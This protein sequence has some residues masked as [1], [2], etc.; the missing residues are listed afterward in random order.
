MK[1]LVQNYKSGELTVREIPAPQL[2]AG[3]VLVRTAYSLISAGTERGMVEMA[4]KSLVEK[5]WSRPDLVRKVLDKARTEGVLTAYKK[6]MLRLST[7]IPLG[8]SS[9][10]TVV[11]VGTGVPEFKSGIQV[12]C[13]GIGYASHSEIVFVPKNLCV[14]VPESVELREAAFT[15]VGTI[16]LQ[17]VR[18]AEVGLGDVVAVIGLGLVGLL[19]VQILKSCGCHVVGMDPDS[20]RC[21]L[22]TELGADATA[23]DGHEHTDA[24]LRLSG[25]LGA[26][27]ALITAATADSGPLELAGES[28]RDRARVVVVGQV[29][30]SVPRKLYYEKELSLLMS[31]SYGPGRYDRS[32]EEKG[33]D[34]PAGYVR[35]TENRNMGA[36][37]KLIAERKLDV[38][39]L[40]THEFPLRRALDAYN[41]IL[42]SRERYL[43]VMLT[44]EASTSAQIS[45]VEIGEKSDRPGSARGTA[46]SSIG[47]GVI[48]SG[49][50]C[51]GVILPALS[52]QAGVSLRG[53]C[54]Q[55]GLTARSVGDRWKFSYCTSDTDAIVNDESTECVIIATRPDSHARLVCAALEAGKHVFVEKPLAVNI[56]QLRQIRNV[57][58]VHPSQVLM[59]GFNRRFSPYVREVKKFVERRTGP[60]MA[61]YRVNAGYLPPTDWQHD[62]E[63]GAGRI[64][65]ESGHFVDTLCYLTGAIPVEVFASSV[66]GSDKDSSAPENAALT[67]RFKDG[68]VGVVFYTTQ[69]SPAFSKERLELFVDG[70]VA[71]IDDFRHIE[72]IRNGSRKKRKD[73]LKQ[74]KGHAAEIEAFLEAVRSGSCPVNRED[75][76]HTTL[77]TLL[78]VESLTSGRRQE[79]SANSLEEPVLEPTECC[80]E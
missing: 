26:D 1:Q 69:G 65:G 23:S 58:A 14:A 34:Y 11:A 13:G 71:V 28:A 42:D 47:V 22:A 70:S 36:I 60:L 7:D 43:G 72:L 3:G 30:M 45:V 79:I 10:G 41:M 12:A 76:F 37:V 48:G 77:C 2:Q 75:Y 52:A 51:T 16:A 50:F 17:G 38:R 24:C 64:V 27:A 25:G 80:N 4:R 29:G 59:V 62:P 78:A 31:R 35:W 53:V 55:R 61:T 20:Q 54:S 40:I 66:T 67:I 8:Y 39:S 68:S 6:A 32:Y 49:S 63:Q 33:V 21:K 56:E 18:A 19:T 44:Y 15:T 9:S 46:P 74:D 57:A 5:A 73:W